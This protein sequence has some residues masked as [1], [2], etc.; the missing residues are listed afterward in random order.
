[1]KAVKAKAAAPPLKAKD[2]KDE[3]KVKDLAPHLLHT[4]PGRDHEGKFAFHK[5]VDVPKNHLSLAYLL[6]AHDV[7]TST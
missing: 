7:N 3:A 5:H 1:M 2:V 4:I 6:H